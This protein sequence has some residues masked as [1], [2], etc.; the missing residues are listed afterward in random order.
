MSLIRWYLSTMSSD[1]HDQPQRGRISRRRLL[2]S[3]AATAAAAAVARP[4]AGARARAEEGPGRHSDGG[5]GG[6]TKPRTAV[7]VGPGFG[8]C[9][10]ALRPGSAGYRTTVLERGRRWDTEGGDDAFPL[11]MAPD[12]RVAWFADHPSINQLTRTTP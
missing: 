4:A 2:G 10:A 9:V 5:I 8:G 1:S 3:V 7:I 12:R 11:L 6:P